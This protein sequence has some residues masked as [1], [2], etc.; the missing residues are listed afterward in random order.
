MDAP[1]PPHGDFATN[2]RLA[3]QSRRTDGPGMPGRPDPPLEHDPAELDDLDVDRPERGR[4]TAAFGGAGD[5][6]PGLG[7]DHGDRGRP[8]RPEHLL[9][10]DGRAAASGRRPTAA[11]TGRRRP[12]TSRPCS[13][14]RSPSAPSNPQ[15]IYAGT[16][17]ANNSSRLVR[18]RQ[19]V[20]KST[21]GGTTWTLL[22]AAGFHPQDDRQDRRRPDQPEDR[23]RRRQRQRGELDAGRTPGSTSRST[24]ASPGPTP[25]R[26]SPRPTRAATWSSTRPTRRSFTR[27][28]APA[29]A[30]PPTG[31]TSRPTAAGPGLPA[32]NFP[33]GDADGRISLAISASNPNEMLA[34]VAKTPPAGVGP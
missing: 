4:N 14:A 31:S 18:R 27:R 25:R 20:L 7:P 23:L 24:A 21:D 22:N 32:G 10:R 13:S 1:L 2:S 6:R 11:R 29:P 17:E 3:A 33:T 15:V 26:R 19:G 30:R 5:R 12:T 9:R 28:S 8:D 34:S 16:G